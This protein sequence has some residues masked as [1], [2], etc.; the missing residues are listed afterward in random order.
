MPRKTL[1]WSAGAIAAA[2]A[3]LA[4]AQS[5]K[6]AAAQP[7]AGGSKGAAAGNASSVDNRLLHAQVLLDTAGF[8]SGVIDGR[9]GSALKQALH[10][11]QEARGLKRSGELDKPTIQALLQ[12]NR[13]AVVQVKLTPDDVQGRFIYPFPSKPEEQAKLP[14]MGYRNMLEKLAERYHTTPATIVALNGPEAKIGVGAT[15]K[16]PN[17]VP[18]SRDYG[19]AD[20]KQAQLLNLLNIDGNQPQGNFIVVDKSDG[21]LRV[22]QGDANAASGKGGKMSGK[23]V[24]QFPVTTGSSHDPLP[25][26]NW[27]ATTYS[28]LPPFNYQ[29]DLFWDVSDDKADQKLPAGPNGPVGVAWLDLTKEHYGIHGT[30]E[31]QTVSKTESHGCLRLTNWDVVRLSRMLKPGFTAVFKA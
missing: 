24:A 3:A 17:V 31:P 10:G 14:F 12:A 7:A 30:P 2:S 9:S 25:L 13:P 20:G 29:P 5:D 6:Q 8:S 26:G 28:F 18:A 4:F 16:L 1:R 27:K 21:V 19:G 22:Y 23:L 11:F 15:L